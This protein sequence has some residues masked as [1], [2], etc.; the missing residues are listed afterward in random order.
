MMVLPYL[1]FYSNDY[2]TMKFSSVLLLSLTITMFAALSYAA[3]IKGRR[4]DPKAKA[5]SEVTPAQQKA[6]EKAIAEERVRAPNGGY[7]YPTSP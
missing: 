4:E 1:K 6:V 2:R 5:E 7:Y 3:P